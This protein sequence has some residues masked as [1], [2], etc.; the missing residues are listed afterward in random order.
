MPDVAPTQAYYGRWAGLYDRLATAPGV[1]SWRRSAVD[2]LAL[3][4]GDTVVEMGCGT[5]ANLPYLRE[6]VGPAGTVV[7]LD[8][9]RGVLERA[10]ERAADR[11]WDNVHVLQADATQPPLEGPVDAILATFVVGMFPD[12]GGAVTDWCDRC[13]DGGRVA[14]LNFQRS[15]HP[16]ATPLNLAFEAV[17]WVNR[18][19]WSLPTASLAGVFEASVG[20]AREA[21]VAR[22]VDRRFETFAGGYLGLLSG[23]V[24]AGGRGDS[25]G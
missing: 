19:G 7:G 11:G 24:A 5:G 17:L 14:L 15:P 12:P 1:A 4:P 6:R 13:A 8:V 18:P 23:R 21:L 3:E 2:A 16:L 22:T 9:T 10:R 20:A 25:N